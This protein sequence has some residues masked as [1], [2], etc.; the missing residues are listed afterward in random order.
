MTDAVPALGSRLMQRRV[1]FPVQAGIIRCPALMNRNSDRHAERGSRERHALPREPR[2]NSGDVF[3]R[4]RIAIRRVDQEIIAKPRTLIVRT[5]APLDRIGRAGNDRA[6]GR[7]PT[8]IVDHL[9]IV[10]VDQQQSSSYSLVRILR[11]A[12]RS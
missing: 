1:G 4:L 11:L 5:N 9:E 3:G 6:A 10:D 7:M 2:E 8:H 12:Q